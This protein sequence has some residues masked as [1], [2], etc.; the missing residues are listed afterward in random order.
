MRLTILSFVFI[1]LYHVSMAQIPFTN[2]NTQSNN[3]CPLMEVS[4]NSNNHNG[5]FEVSYCNHGNSTAVNAYVEIEITNDLLITQ[6]TIPASSVVGE[7]YTF[8]LGD[9]NS[10][11]CAAFYIE[12]PNA[13]NK[14]HCANVHIFPDDP[15]QAMIDQYIINHNTLNGN[16]DNG[17]NNGNSNSNSDASLASAVMQYSAPGPPILGVGTVSVYEDHIF[18]D[19]IPTW[20]SLINVLTNSGILPRDNNNT[21]SG[22]VNTVV[23]LSTISDLSSA[24]LCSN[25]GNTGGGIIVNQN[26][27]NQTTTAVVNDLT[28]AGTTTVN[29]DQINLN[30]TILETPKHTQEQEVINVRLF[31]NPF[32]TSATITIDGANYQQTILEVLD[33]AGKSIRSI[34]VNEE[35]R[36]ILNRENLSQ[37]VYFYRLIGDNAIVHTGKFIVR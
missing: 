5:I 18:L 34:Q 3:N 27:L 30:N 8:H 16:D 13:D 17:N 14:M 21:A 9:V 29:N 2:N 23:D 22:T 10:S 26:I 25:Q 7:T 32:S 19:N 36:I 4:I 15:C 28:V 12:V 33:I 20:D 31:P 1:V 24:E 6:S 11:E 37:G 35:Q